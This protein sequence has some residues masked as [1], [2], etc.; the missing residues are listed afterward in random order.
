MVFNFFRCMLLLF[1][2]SRS[3]LTGSLNQLS[4]H[5]CFCLCF[6]LIFGIPSTVNT[7]KMW[8]LS[9]DSASYYPNIYGIICRQHPV[10]TTGCDLLWAIPTV[11]VLPY[12]VC[13]SSRRCNKISTYCGRYEQSLSCLIMSVHQVEDVIKFQIRDDFKMLPWGNFE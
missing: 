6:S 9:V 13:P 10:D 3:W 11:S 5:L 1:C 8:Y 12:N 4:N 2:A 7:L